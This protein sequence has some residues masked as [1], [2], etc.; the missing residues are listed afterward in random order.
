VPPAVRLAAA[1]QQYWQMPE[2][3]AAEQLQLAQAA[4]TRS[5]A[6]LRC[7]N[8]GSTSGPAA[9][10]GSGGKRCSGCRVAW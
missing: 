9:G 4:A 5:C 1:L 7:A 2:Q 3:V 10:R 8:V 6:Y